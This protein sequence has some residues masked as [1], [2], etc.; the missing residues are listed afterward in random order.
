MFGNA[1]NDTY[2]IDSARDVIIDDGGDI[3]DSIF[4]SI[5]IDLSA[6]SY[7]NIEL[8]T[9]VGS[10]ALNVTGNDQG[11]DLTGN[12]GANR[13]S[14]GG[15]LDVLVG[16][17]GNDTLDGGAGDDILSGGAGND[18]F[19]VDSELEVVIGEQAGRAG[20][21]DTVFS[22]AGDYELSSNVENLVLLTGALFGTG[23]D[24]SNVITGN[25]AANFLG[26][27]DNGSDTLRGGAGND[28]LDG[29]T[30]G[31]DSMAGGAGNDSFEVDDG[32]KVSE[33][34]G[35]TGGID[36]VE[37]FGK[38][39]FTL[40]ANI[41]N[42]R[43]RST[44][45]FTFG[46]GNNLN[47]VIEGDSSTNRLSGLGGND[48]ITGGFGDDI[49]DGGSGIDTLSGGDGNDIYVVDSVLDVIL[50]KGAGGFDAVQSSVSFDLTAN[51]TTVTSDLA[52]L[53]L[54]GN[55]AIN[56][57][58]NGRDNTIEGN[59]AAN[60]LDG[61]A[62]NDSLKGGAGNDRLI[63]GADAG[64]DTLDGGTG[65]D[66]L[67]GG[68]GNDIYLVDNAKDKVVETSAA[69]SSDFVVASASYILSDNIE[70]LTLIGTAVSGA[71]NAQGN[72]I[73]GNGLANKLFGLEGADTL[74]GNL[75]NDSLDGGKGIDV[76]VGGD[77]NDTYFVD[78]AGDTV[79][80]STG[81]GIDTV[82]AS[83]SFSLAP[84]LA[85]A[86]ENL[87]LAAGAGDIDATCN[88][89]NNLILGNEGRNVLNGADGND[90][91]SGNGGNDFL[92]GGAGGDSLDGGAGDDSLAGSTGD[93]TLAGGAG[94]DR[95]LYDSP[96]DGHDLIRGFDGNAA[97][98]QDTLD[99][100]ALFD[101]LGTATADR[102]G[103]VQIADRGANVDVRVDT[104]GDGI[105]DL[106]A[107]TLQ[108]ADAITVGAD[109]AV[110]TL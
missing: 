60:V 28:T 67:E 82:V 78:S 17:N 9:L 8:V 109:I 25:D 51:G 110:G 68:D 64:S 20:G 50:D 16:L 97:G 70:G 7:K 34:G 39:G 10:K 102:E 49:L 108:T 42:L 19:I 37:Y 21:I 47:N 38:V 35:A 107:A 1:G 106:F 90:T 77:G 40:G 30:L 12:A 22:S 65:V 98:G 69:I 32:D 45:P 5:S 33:L 44:G 104:D 54:T 31:K 100:E 46:I 66:T 74:T 2:V 53:F 62:G 85:A 81:S 91:L 59:A 99:L 83:V 93:D 89:Q 101:T 24:L 15:G 86:V 95:F 58:G 4:A 75:G 87:T 79:D 103:R 73:I 94:N 29:G 18:T 76:L 27:G 3:G 96:L 71:G 56:G 43:L 55:R 84:A 72:G 11:N 92:S 105:F 48:S 80:E 61:G 6:G 36:L 23:N 52:F 14:G 88:G 26:G 13:L 63:G 41:E 57:T